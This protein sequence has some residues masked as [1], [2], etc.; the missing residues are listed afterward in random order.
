MHSGGVVAGSTEANKR[1]VVSE[2]LKSFLIRL[3]ANK[4]N[5]WRVSGIVFHHFLSQSNGSMT[6]QVHPRPK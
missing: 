4:L 6:Y 1:K 3:S 2:L 5:G